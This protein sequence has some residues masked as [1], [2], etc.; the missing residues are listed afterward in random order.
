MAAS[1]VS[2]DSRTGS[3]VSWRATPS[4]AV[5]SSARS[6]I[7]VSRARCRPAASIRRY[8]RV[9][10]SSSW[11]EGSASRRDLSHRVPPANCRVR[12][13]DRAAW[14]RPRRVAPSRTT[15]PSSSARACGPSSSWRV[16]PVRAAAEE[17]R[18]RGVT[19]RGSIPRARSAAS[20]PARLPRIRSTT[21]GGTWVSAPTVC[22]P[23]RRSASACREPSPYSSSTGRGSRKPATASP[24]T[25]RTPPGPGIRAE[26]MDAT[27]QVAATPIRTSVPSRATARS[28]TTSAMRAGPAPKY[29]WAPRTWTSAARGGRAWTSGENSRSSSSTSR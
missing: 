2:R 9:R 11:A 1:T 21:P 29:R 15:R 14:R 28:R 27:A 19:G 6:T 13:R 25:A 20:R 4:A 18:S 10:R 7:P 24:G 17:G 8:A 5:R 12:D 3:S 16:N 26:A 22:S 23:Y